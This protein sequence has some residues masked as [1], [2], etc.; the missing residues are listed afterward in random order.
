METLLNDPDLRRRMGVAS[1]ERAITEFSYEM[2]AERLGNV[3]GV[4]S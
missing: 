3:F 4:W 1:R 2:L